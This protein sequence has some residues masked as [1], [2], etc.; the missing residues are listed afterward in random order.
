MHGGY[1]E[2]TLDKINETQELVISTSSC[3]FSDWKKT[4]IFASLVEFLYFSKV[5]QIP[6]LYANVELGVS[7]KKL[8]ELFIENRSKHLIIDE[9]LSYFEDHAESITHGGAE[10]ILS[11]EWG[12][13][14]WPPGEYAYLS[15]VNDEKLDDLYKASY[16]IL[17]NLTNNKEE[18]NILSD[19]IKYNAFKISRPKVEKQMIDLNYPIDDFYA[20]WLYN[21]IPTKKKAD[22]EFTLDDVSNYDTFSDWAQKVVWY[23]H[24]TGAYLYGDIRMEKDIAGH[25]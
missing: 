25:Y 5:L 18:K 1:E 20:G 16:S 7:Y 21:K 2:E 13:V 12:G 3:N 17:Q 15:L 22:F 11:K 6:L 8:I 4:R 19:S 24:R 9:V 10:F 14:Y 23:G